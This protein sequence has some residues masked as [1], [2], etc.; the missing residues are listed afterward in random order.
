MIRYINRK[1]HTV[2]PGDVIM[3]IEGEGKPLEVFD[4]L[5]RG[6]DGTYIPLVNGERYWVDGGDSVIRCKA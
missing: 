6:F 4:T 1:A 5:R 3:P 2:K